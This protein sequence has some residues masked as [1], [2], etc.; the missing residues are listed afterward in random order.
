[1]CNSRYT[2]LRY[3]PCSMGSLTWI[4][5]CFLILGFKSHL[6][7][8]CY[9]M[10]E[11]ARVKAV[12]L[13]GQEQETADLH[14]RGSANW[15]QIGVL[16]LFKLPAMWEQLGLTPGYSMGLREEDGKGKWYLQL[17]SELWYTSVWSCRLSRINSGYKTTLIKIQQSN[18]YL[19]WPKAF[20]IYPFNEL[21]PC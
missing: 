20:S 3:K 14:C 8:P 10:C 9:C 18:C 16:Q 2:Q 13:A 11:T 21:T 19:E 17:S 7:L 5:L 1:M 12:A 15:Y 6:R 4:P